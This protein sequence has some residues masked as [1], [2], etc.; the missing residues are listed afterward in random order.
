MKR[1]LIIGFVVGI[2]VL[3]AAAAVFAVWFRRSPDVIAPGP[4]N[5][6]AYASPA[7]P[8]QPPAYVVDF[9]SPS[10]AGAVEFE[11]ADQPTIT[12]EIFY[13]VFFRIPGKSRQE[14]VGWEGLFGPEGEASGVSILDSPVQW[15]SADTAVAALAPPGQALRLTLVNVVSGS[16]K[17]LQVPLDNLFGYAINSDKTKIGIVGKKDDLERKQVLLTTLVY[18][19]ASD[20]FRK[21]FEYTTTEPTGSPLSGVS[22]G[23]DG[24]LYFDMART[25]KPAIMVYDPNTD[26]VSQFADAALWPLVSPDGRYV[27]Y[28]SASSIYRDR[29]PNPPAVVITAFDGS[30][31]Q[32]IANATGRMAWSP[33]A[34]ALA[35][36]YGDHLWVHHLEP[37]PDGITTES[38]LRA[39]A[40][41][42]GFEHG[43]L[44]VD[45]WQIQAGHRYGLQRIPK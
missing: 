36:A 31:R 30:V 11:G 42:L 6:P 7:T 15:L 38:Q 5:P 14:I 23:A 13:R 18:D 33:D 24:K 25:E 41:R 37:L 26:V 4:V 1:N 8:G 12:G 27:A 21:V 35:I 22:W 20:S 19:L 44:Y 2:S 32:T 16:V 10:G 40:A 28:V 9:P 34:S 43:Q 45:V 39:P 17:D 29:D 3:A